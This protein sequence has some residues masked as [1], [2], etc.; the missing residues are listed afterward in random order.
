LNARAA[1]T[2]I[3]F[4]AA[5]CR[6]FGYPCDPLLIFSVHQIPLREALV[7]VAKEGVYGVFG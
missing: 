3:V 1:R 5:G 4:A 6:A 2:W 7:V